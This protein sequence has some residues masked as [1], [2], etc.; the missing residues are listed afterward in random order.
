MSRELL[1]GSEAIALAMISAGLT[2][3]TQAAAQVIL[4]QHEE[5]GGGSVRVDATIPDFAPLGFNDRASS[6][7]VAGHRSVRSRSAIAVPSSASGRT[8]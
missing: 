3:A 5:F 6:A 8:A 4:Y 1:E 7:I 2:L